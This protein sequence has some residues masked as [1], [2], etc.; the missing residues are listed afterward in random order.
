MMVKDEADVIE[1]TVKHLLREVDHVIVSDNDSSDGTSEILLRLRGWAGGRLTVVSDGEAGYYQSDKTTALA[2]TAAGLGHDWVVPV[3]ADE[4]WY[5]PFGRLGDV[6]DGLPAGFLFA[7]GAILNHVCCPDVDPA[8]EPDPVRRLGWRIRAE[9][10]L[11]KVACRALPDLRIE[12]GNH[13]ATARGLVSS[14]WS[15]TIA[16]QVYIHHY[17]WRSAEQFERKIANGARAYAAAPEIGEDF[18][19]HWRRFGMPD[20]EGFS[21]RVRAWFDE[22]GCRHGR[23]P[24][25][26]EAAEELLYDPA[27]THNGGTW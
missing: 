26:A 25:P 19:D 12:M 9:G 20:D 21:G 24:A 11:P 14:S 17:P 13:G 15:P 27:V 6:L 18:G 2:G 23:P 8:G 7:A 1:T 10:D 22:W 16:G 5:S 3:D 4:I